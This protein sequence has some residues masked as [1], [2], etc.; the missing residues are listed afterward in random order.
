MSEAVSEPIA[1]LAIPELSAPDREPAR[2]ATS[3]ADRRFYVGLALATIIH[4]LIFAG[5]Y[6]AEPR[7]IGDPSGSKD[8]IS[9]NFVT[10]AEL[11]GVSAVPEAAKEPPAPP[12][13]PPAP[14]PS[15]PAETAAV[16]PPTPPSAPAAKPPEPAAKPPEAAPAATPAPAPEASIPDTALSLKSLKERE[17]P[18]EPK[19]ADPPKAEAPK[20]VPQ[21]KPSR[22]ARLDLSPPAVISAPSG[23]GG[24]GVQRPPGITRSGENDAFARGV[25][26][27]LRRTM[28]QLIETQGRVTVRVTLDKDGSLV[29][30]QVVRASNIAGLDRSVVFATRQTSYPFPPRNARSADLVF[31]ITYIYQ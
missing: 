10:D 4:S 30:T 7:I 6:R 25:V 29:S 9:V 1:D 28:P 2:E 12:A 11:R 17:P 14:P 26:S 31:L 16:T 20:P 24:A 3:K 8:A 19:P 21:T 5:F 23:S 13:P 15:P 22:S 27:A 18:I